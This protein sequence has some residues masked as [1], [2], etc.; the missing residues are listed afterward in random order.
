[1]HDRHNAEPEVELMGFNGKDSIGF[2]ANGFRATATTMQS[3]MVNRADVIKHQL[4]HCREKQI[5]C[6]LQ[7]G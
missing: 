2:P 1:M 7:A 5:S 3:E 4:T 6:K